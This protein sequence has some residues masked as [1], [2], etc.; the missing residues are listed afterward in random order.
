MVRPSRPMT[1][2]SASATNT[3]RSADCPA[4]R[5]GPARR[6]PSRGLR[7]E[8]RLR[9][10]GDRSHDLRGAGLPGRGLQPLPA[11]VGRLHRQH[12]PRQRRHVRHAPRRDVRLVGVVA[13]A[14][15]P[16]RAARRVLHPR[17]LHR[18]VGPGARCALCARPAER[19]GDRRLGPRRRAVRALPALRRPPAR[20]RLGRRAGVGHA[21]LRRPARPARGH[22]LA[23]RPCPAGR[24]GGRRGRAPPDRARAAA[25]GL[26]A[27]FRATLDR[28]GAPGGVR[29]ASP[30]RWTSRRS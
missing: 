28:R 26:L 14:G 12:R 29:R 30:A 19:A 13:A 27:A 17:G 20:H 11:R 16:L 25:A 5:A 6:R 21:P 10:L 18:L 4:A 1:E 8:P 24:A 15:G 23:D 2:P 22:G 3:S 9:A 7:S